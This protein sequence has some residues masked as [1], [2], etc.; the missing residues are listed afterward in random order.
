MSQFSF[1]CNQSQIFKFDI[2]GYHLTSKGLPSRALAMRCDVYKTKH[3][4]R[5]N[6][7]TFY[8]FFKFWFI[9]INLSQEEFEK[10]NSKT[11]KRKILKTNG[12]VSKAIAT[13]DVLARS[14]RWLGIT[15]AVIDTPEWKQVSFCIDKYLKFHSE[16]DTQKINRTWKE[17]E[18]NIKD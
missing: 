13:A 16:L 2:V 18:L 12:S 6:S 15:E 11:F 3:Q 5:S 10:K 14:Q 8:I 9:S 4:T 7:S 17:S 1:V